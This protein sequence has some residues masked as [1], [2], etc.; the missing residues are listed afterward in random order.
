[1][2]CEESSTAREHILDRARTIRELLTL[3]ERY[4]GLFAVQLFQGFRNIP[5][6]KNLVAGAHQ[7]LRDSFEKCDVRTDCCD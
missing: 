6:N 3:N 1:M 2:K 7:C 4:E 5:G